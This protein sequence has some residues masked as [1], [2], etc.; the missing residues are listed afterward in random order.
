[1]KD[2]FAELLETD[3]EFQDLL[4]LIQSKPLDEK[5]MYI[6]LLYDLHHDRAQVDMDTFLFDKDFMGIKPNQI[7]AKIR[8]LLWIIDDPAVREVFIVAGKGSGKST[9]VGLAQAK[10]LY[11]LLCYVD[12]A[13]YFG[14]MQGT[15][16][17]LI[18]MSISAP[19]ALNVIFKRFISYIQRIKQFQKVSKRQFVKYKEIKE[20]AKETLR[21]YKGGDID[22][23][24]FSE[25]VGTL[26]FTDKSIMCLSGHS[27]FSSFFGYDTFFG[28]IDEMSWFKTGSKKPT[29][30]LDNDDIAG[31]IYQ[32]L[33]SAGKTRFPHHYTVIGISSPRSKKDDLLWEK[34]QAIKENGEEIRLDLDAPQLII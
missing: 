30:D 19:Q 8:E 15:F 2:L 25:S 21:E 4:E 11:N 28:S 34:V 3:S 22:T 24:F 27:K 9:L 17:V 29:G 23:E 12:P 20:G 13:A 14:L 6:N 26:E 7:H 16:I 33:V 1:M 10:A 5:D 18:N 31:E 32:G